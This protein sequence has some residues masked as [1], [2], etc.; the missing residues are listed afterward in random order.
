[1]PYLAIDLETT[2]L[3]VDNHQILEIGA[4]FNCYS[5][6]VIECDV[7]RRTVHYS[8]DIVGSPFALA[9]NAPL[10]R[11]IAEGESVNIR[12]ACADFRDWLNARGI[13]RDNKVTLLGKNVGSF[14]W[15]LLRRAPGF[16]AAYINYRMLDVGSMYATPEGISGQAELCEAVAKKHNIP[17]VEHTA[18]YDARV[19]L[20]LAREKW[21]GEGQRHLRLPAI[22]DIT[23]YDITGP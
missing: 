5:K 21:F 8:A 9:M 11:Q 6:P 15:Q 16:P 4:V 22:K 23:E 7:F 20:A 3:D 2:G 14:D 10:L 17:G 1:M 13:D 18:V 19:S 12:N